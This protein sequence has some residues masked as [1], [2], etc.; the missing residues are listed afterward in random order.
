MVQISE[1]VTVPLL[2]LVPLLVEKQNV[3]RKLQESFL[4]M[5]A[6]EILR[7]KLVIGIINN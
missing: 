2:K 7:V 6:D 4:F 1:Y 3:F 5:M